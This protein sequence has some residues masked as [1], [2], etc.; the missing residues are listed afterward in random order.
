MDPA[1]FRAQLLDN[2]F[3]ADW[4]SLPALDK[5][6]EE[7]LSRKQDHSIRIN[8]IVAFLAWRKTGGL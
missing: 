4:F 1:W 7:H 2:P 5:L 6:L 8:N 3:A